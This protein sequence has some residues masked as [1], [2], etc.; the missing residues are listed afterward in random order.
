[1]KK[2]ILSILSVVCFV[3]VSFA[4]ST[5]DIIKQDPLKA[6]CSFYVYDYQNAPEV[7]PAPEGYKP[8]Y[9]SQFAR[10]G[11][12]YCTSEYNRLYEWFSKAEEAGVLTREGKKFFARY[13][14]FY[15]KVKDCG[16]NLTGVGKAQHRAIAEHMY[17]RFPSVFEG[18]TRVEAVSTESSRVIMSMWSCL[19]V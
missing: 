8:F 17:Q 4:Q 5:A 14:T 7:T 16:G 10:H 11:A 2:V 15:Q 13:K 3:L 9:I 19:L 18:P 1:M 6:A 12:R